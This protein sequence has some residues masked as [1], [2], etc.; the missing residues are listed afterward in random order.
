MTLCLTI[1]RL[2]LGVKSAPAIQR[3]LISLRSVPVASILMEFGSASMLEAKIKLGFDFYGV[4]RNSR[5]YPTGT[6]HVLSAHSLKWLRGVVVAL[7]YA[8][9]LDL[10]PLGDDRQN[11]PMVSLRGAWSK[12]SSCNPSQRTSCA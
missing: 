3:N 4:P 5:N 2:Y 8:P 6:C 12:R 7:S 1:K 11:C 10:W 9:A